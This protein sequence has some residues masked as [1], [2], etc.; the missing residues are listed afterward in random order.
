MDPIIDKVGKLLETIPAYEADAM[1]WAAALSKRGVLTNLVSYQNKLEN[2]L[3]SV[4]DDPADVVVTRI[5]SIVVQYALHTTTIVA[6]DA[7][8]LK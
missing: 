7:N 8:D 6:T 5:K 3:T 4:K 1:K 2:R